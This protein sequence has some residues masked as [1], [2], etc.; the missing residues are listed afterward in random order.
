MQYRVKV[1][2]Y[3]GQNRTTYDA[4]DYDIDHIFDIQEEA[5]SHV[6]ERMRDPKVFSLLLQ[7]EE[8]PKWRQSDTT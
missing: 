3:E 1:A 6:T 2:S 5:I 8:V 4:T 7:K